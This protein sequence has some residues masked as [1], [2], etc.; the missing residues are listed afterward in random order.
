MWIMEIPRNSIE[1]GKAPNCRATNA[2]K[3]SLNLTIQR[4]RERE[5]EMY[6]ECERVSS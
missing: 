4:E 6:W 3:P 5:R 1:E 2:I